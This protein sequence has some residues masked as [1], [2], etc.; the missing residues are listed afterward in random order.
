MSAKLTRREYTN[1]FRSE[2]TSWLLGNVGDKISL[3][4]DFEINVATTSSF[5]NQFESNGVDTIT[6]NVGN[7][8]SDGFFAGSFIGWSTTV[9]IGGGSPVAFVGTG[10]ITVLTPTSMIVSV[11]GWTFPPAYY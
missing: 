7:F 11:S 4:L 9:S 10:T 5:S 2:K 3:E 6:Q 8:N 1:Q